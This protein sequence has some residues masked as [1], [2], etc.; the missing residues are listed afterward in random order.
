MNL[1]VSVTFLDD[2]EVEERMDQAAKLIA[3]SFVR[4]FMEELNKN[5]SPERVVEDGN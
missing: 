1:D 2:K 3:K 5:V 4:R